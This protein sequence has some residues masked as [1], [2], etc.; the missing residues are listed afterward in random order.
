MVKASIVRNLNKVKL[1]IG[2]GFDLYCGLKTSYADFFGFRKTQ[3]EKV[4][5]WAKTFTNIDSFLS[6]ENNEEFWNNLDCYN[7]LTAWDLLFCFCS[8]EKINEIPNWN[9]CNIEKIML[10]SLK[11]PTSNVPFWQNVYLSLTGKN[12]N[13]TISLYEKCI[14]AFI[15]RSPDK[16]K[17]SSENK[18][19][20]YLLDKLKIFE[21]SFGKFIRKATF[22]NSVEDDDDYDKMA[23][24]TIHRFCS[25]ENIS[26]IDTFNYDEPKI[27]TLESKF[28]HINGDLE[29]P[30]FGV[31]SNFFS[32]SD[33]RYLFTKTCRRMEW[34]M[35]KRI[36]KSISDFDNIIIFGHSLDEADYS[37]FFSIFD[38]LNIADIS[39]KAKIVFGYT[40]YKETLEDEIL[41]ST[42]VCIARLFQAY[43]NMS[44]PIFAKTDF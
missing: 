2:N 6:K 40:I 34:N 37:Y 5:K 9:W 15:K 30:I 32:P 17:L 14:A 12:L 11:E 44:F 35:T 18:F 22:T 41:V 29:N 43:A 10:D 3:Y 36:E 39:C 27:R 38:K 21:K 4:I 16:M 24:R 7:D 26:C 1:V 13:S 25:L 33:S 42:R 19:Y 23:R 28:T 20:S 8:Y 31:D